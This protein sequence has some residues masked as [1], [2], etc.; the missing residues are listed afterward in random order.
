[1]ASHAA[2][3]GA[4]SCERERT[5]TLA[6]QQQSLKQCL[7]PQEPAQSSRSLAGCAC[8]PPGSD[9]VPPA[10]SPWH[11]MGPAR[12]AS[13]AVHPARPW[14]PGWTGPRHADGQPSAP[15]LHAVLEHRHSC[16]A[17]VRAA[18]TAHAKQRPAHRQ[19]HAWQRT[20]RC[21]VLHKLRT[22]EHAPPRRCRRGGRGVL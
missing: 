15:L 17:D 10:C 12:P 16:T 5:G 22:H 14:L 19:P 13:A 2:R 1:M 6:R 4:C 21:T 9:H 8:H 18:N 7:A 3:S 20:I 11:V